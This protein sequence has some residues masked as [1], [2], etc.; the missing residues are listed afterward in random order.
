[1]RA[2][3]NGDEAAAAWAKPQKS[4]LDELRE[5]ARFDPALMKELMVKGQQAQR[6][7]EARRGKPMA[8]AG[9]QKYLADVLAEQRAQGLR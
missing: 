9:R 5:R 2:E 7:R 1:M 6:E 8:T 3:M 4:E